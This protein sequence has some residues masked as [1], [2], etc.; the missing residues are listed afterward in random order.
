M[1]LLLH[2]LRNS[3]EP[4]VPWGKEVNFSNCKMVIFSS[5][6]WLVVSNMFYFTPYSGKIPILANIFQ[7]G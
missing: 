6:V 2:V 3:S 7:R 1:G 5:C 4:W